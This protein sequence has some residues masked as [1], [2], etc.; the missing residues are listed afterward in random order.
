MEQKKN[1][2]KKAQVKKGKKMPFLT[3]IDRKEG[4]GGKKMCRSSFCVTQGWGRI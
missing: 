4:K 2:S 1:T 3:L